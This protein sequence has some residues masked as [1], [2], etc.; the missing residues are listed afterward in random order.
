[1]KRKLQLLTGIGCLCL[2]FLSC[3][4]PPYK[5]PALS[6][7]ERANDLVGRLT[8]E[9]KAS[10]MQ[11]TSPAIPRLG[12]KAYDWWNEA[13]HGV[14]RAGLATV[15][16]Q[17]IGMGASFNNELLYDVFTAVS[18][19]ARAKNTEFSK[20]AIRK[21]ARIAATEA[22]ADGISWTFSPMVDIS[23]D[24]RWGRGQETYGED[25]YLTGQM[26]MAVVRGLQGPEGEKYDKL[27]ACA[28]HYA[29]HSGPEWN[30]HSFN[31]EN[32]DPRDLWET[33]LPAFKDLVQK[34]HVKEV[35]CAY[36]RFEGEPCCGSNRL[37]MQILRDEWGY[38]EIVVSDCWAIS[39]FY[40][41]GAHETDPDKQHASAKAVLSGTDVECGDSYASLPEAV[42]EGLI[43][44]KQIDISL[45]RLM[46]ARF[47]LGE[48]DEPSQV[49]WAQIPYSV[50]DSKE[51]RELALRM[52][53]ES[54]VLLQNNQSLLPLNKNLKVAVV[55]P[56]ANDSVMQ[57]GNYNGFPSHTITLLEG[58][59]EYLPESQIIYEPGCDLTSDVT[60]Q[61]VFQQCSMD[62]KQGFSAKYWNNTKQ[63]GTPDV[64]NHI[65]T[66][67]HFIT[68]GATTF[69]A[70]I[71]LQDFSASYESVFRPAKSED[72]AFRFQT[73]GITKLSID[74]KEVA[75]GMNFKNKSKVYTLQ[76]EAGKEYRIKIDFAFRN[77]DA[78]LDF[79]MGR[80]VPV[81]LK[82]TVD[83]VKEAD[84]VIFVGGISPDFEGEEK[85]N[86]EGYGFSGG[87]RTTIELP[88]VQRDILR[89]LKK[90]GKKVIFVNCSGS[91]V[92]LEPEMDSCD[93]ILQAWYPGQAGGQAVAEVLFGDYNPA[94]K[95]PLTFYRN[96]A[97]IP[98]FEDY[99]MTGRTYRYM[100][101][102][103]L[104][105]F[106]HGLSYT[107]FKYGKLKMNDDKIA[108]GQNLNL[109]IPVTNTGSRDGDEVVQVYL[110]KKDDTEGPVKTLRAFKRVRIP[111][112]KTVEVK[113]SLDDTQ[114]E[115]WDEQSNTMRVC[116]GNYTVMIG[117]TSC[118]KSL[119][120]RAFTI[121]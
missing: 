113:F 51:H 20:E 86:I 6:P 65:S 47:E 44:E 46:K 89:A 102:T 22:S 93:A 26:G 34:A 110:K 70:G 60:L 103:P 54:L 96:L 91:A 111:A 63:E 43:D 53:R 120:S 55:G 121:R 61:S 52:A 31:A 79:D 23:R 40:N 85:Y 25:P 45:K 2:C 48:M 14:G 39:D 27:H 59:R 35:M 56:N 7:E 100:K 98:D 77:R 32:I 73:Q 81:D 78:A 76:A 90:A 92:A 62:G 108:A 58:I 82:Q 13:L 38:K 75:A 112:G 41:K 9:E 16:P 42:K 57:W 116:P 94:G 50:V 84:V 1:M 19:E 80:E 33:Y 106:G 21:S 69:A 37:L 88:Q 10:L 29:V 12:I 104:F 5:N 28:K 4:Q 115:W 119:L 118:E 97:Q 11:N 15:F 74:G 30:R 8:L 17:A 101:E 83:K 107:T 99:N 64:T 109:V 49:S 68:T 105:P 87:D 95:L 114:L 36:N 18:D 72:I 24:P 71:N 67:F 66:P 117:G 3:S